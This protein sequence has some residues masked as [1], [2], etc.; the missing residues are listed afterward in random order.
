VSVPIFCPYFLPDDHEVIAA[1]TY[2][3]AIKST[4]KMLYGEQFHGEIK[5]VYNDGSVYLM[6]FLKMA[7]K[8]NQKYR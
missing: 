4:S 1:S 7:K 2:I 3:Q 8:K 6:N 5:A